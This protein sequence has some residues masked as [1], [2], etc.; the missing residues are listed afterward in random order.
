MTGQVRWVNAAD[1]GDLWEGD[2]LDVEVDDE[3]VLL[4]H[5]EGGPVKAYQGMCPHQEVLLADG[6]WDPDTNVLVCPGHRWEF[7]MATGKGLNPVGC[8]LYE[9]A[10]QVVSDEIRVAVPQDGVRHHNRFQT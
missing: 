5:L 4:V 7:D 6:E 3:Q 1:V 9:F 2:V 10:V 8:Q